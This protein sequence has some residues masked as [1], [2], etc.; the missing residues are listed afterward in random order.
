MALQPM[1][2]RVML[3]PIARAN[4]KRQPLAAGR[5]A[6]NKPSNAIDHERKTPAVS[7]EIHDARR[8]LLDRAECGVAVD[9]HPMA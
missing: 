4:P 6:A 5:Q 1:D 8:R 3:I 9:G 7:V 2:R